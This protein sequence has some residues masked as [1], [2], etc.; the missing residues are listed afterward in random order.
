MARILANAATRGVYQLPST[1]KSGMRIGLATVTSSV[2]LGCA[3]KPLYHMSFSFGM[4][5]Q[6]TRDQVC[7]LL[8]QPDVLPLVEPSRFLRVFAILGVG[9]RGACHTR[10]RD[11]HPRVSSQLIV[12]IGFA[13]GMVLV[14]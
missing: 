2:D 12:W 7:Y 10:K 4:G 3:I 13:K 5:G 1:H 14:R 9:G 8:L 6:K 11:F